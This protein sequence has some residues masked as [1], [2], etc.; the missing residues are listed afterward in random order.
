[1]L[2]AATAVSAWNSTQAVFTAKTIVPRPSDTAPPGTSAPITPTPNPV[3]WNTTNV[4][5]HFEASGSESGIA[6]VTADV[7][8]TNEGRIIVPASTL[9]DNRQCRLLPE[10]PG[11]KRHSN[12]LKILRAIRG[13]RGYKIHGL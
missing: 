12:D 3:G 13:I 8:L 4:V 10:W 6:F 11:S 5:V 7:T 9:P 2:I 1:M